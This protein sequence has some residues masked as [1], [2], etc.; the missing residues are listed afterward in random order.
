MT[1]DLSICEK[2]VI[3]AEAHGAVFEERNG[4]YNA[5]SCDGHGRFPTKGCAAYEYCKAWNMLP[6]N[7]VA[8]PADKQ[9]IGDTKHD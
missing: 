1:D 4:T 6:P 2:C 3:I 9:C 8:F 7:G 5:W